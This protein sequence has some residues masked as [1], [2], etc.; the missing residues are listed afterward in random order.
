MGNAS[1]SYERQGFSARASFNYQGHYVLAVGNTAADDNWLDNRLEIDFSASQRI[2][3]HIRV[4]FD[5]L[6]LGNE[7]YRV[8]IG[9]AEPVDSGGA[10][11]DLGHHRLQIRFLNC[12][13]SH[14][15]I[16]IGT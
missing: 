10:L 8:Y 1:I 3:K 4:F 15:P 12:A 7:P 13:R 2:N 14:S 5:M 11:Q 6:N 9:T 16:F